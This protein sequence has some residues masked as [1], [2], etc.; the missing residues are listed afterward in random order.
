MCGASDVCAARSAPLPLRKVEGDACFR[1]PGGRKTGD[2]GNVLVELYFG[3]CY[4]GAH[5]RVTLDGLVRCS[6]NTNLLRSEIL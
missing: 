2:L 3:F 1:W 6:Q 5:A 4:A